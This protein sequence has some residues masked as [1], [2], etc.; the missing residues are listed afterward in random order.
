MVRPA[1]VMAEAVVALSQSVEPAV[2]LRRTQEG[3][4]SMP[5]GWK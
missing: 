4:A 2:L 3:A 5:G 1:L